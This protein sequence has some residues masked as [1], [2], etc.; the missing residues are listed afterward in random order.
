MAVSQVNSFSVSLDGESYLTGTR[1]STGDSAQKVSDTIP[2]GAVGELTAI[3]PFDAAKL[4]SFFLQADQD[5]EL[6]FHN[7]GTDPELVL[8]LTANEPQVWD[9][10]SFCANPFGT[11][12]ID[13]VTATN[14]SGVAALLVGRIVV[15]A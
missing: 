4:E 6:T 5:L 13:S 10:G 1:T 7:S 8:S 11:S 9:N 3:A 2:I 14:A 15:V 12:V